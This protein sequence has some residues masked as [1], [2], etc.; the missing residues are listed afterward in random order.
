MH[1][2]N[3]VTARDGNDKKEGGLLWDR[4]GRRRRPP[5]DRCPDRGPLDGETPGLSPL[6]AGGQR[7][8]RREGR[9]EAAGQRPEASPTRGALVTGPTADV[10]GGGRCPAR[11]SLRGRC[12]SGARTT[13]FLHDA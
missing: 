2:E 6:V 11:L 3:S 12:L 4:L 9:R 1:K 8:K 13:G 7:R 10:L 5:P